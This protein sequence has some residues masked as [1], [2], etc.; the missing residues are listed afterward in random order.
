MA[1]GNEYGLAPEQ[2]QYRAIEKKHGFLKVRRNV[3]IEVDPDDP[4]KPSEETS[5]A[6]SR[7]AA[8]TESREEPKL[9]KEEKEDEVD[10]RKGG[11]SDDETGEAED[12][13]EAEDEAEDKAEAED[14][15]EDER[16][17]EPGDE[18][19]KPPEPP[20]LEFADEED[21]RAYRAVMRGE[22]LPPLRSR[23]RGEGEGK[24]KGKGKKKAGPKKDRQREERRDD[25]RSR[26][27]ERKS[28]GGGGR[29][30]RK[31]TG[32][33]PEPS[34]KPRREGRKRA[35]TET[36]SISR[37]EPK[38]IEPIE[39]R[40]KKAR[41][42]KA[43]AALEASEWLLDLVDLDVDCE[44]YEG[45]ERFEVEF[46]GRDRKFLVADSGKVL[47]GL[48]H[49][50]PRVMRG[51]CGEGYPIRT[52]SENFQVMREERLKDEALETAARVRREGEPAVLDAM[53]PADRRIVHI[54]LTDDP[55]VTTRSLGDGYFKRVKILPK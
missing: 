10:D 31:E 50:I 33:R 25:R 19:E 7:A 28:G 9:S 44:V 4:R 40:L 41:G 14:E 54:T 32:G 23:K 45:E 35:E 27:G 48:E 46:R 20:D 16:E 43:K 5:K 51:I 11:L 39:K 30:D 15:P 42:E 24:G 13:G 34:R 18:E 52:D 1:A 22:A 29:K 8:A 36:R 47:T 12:S 55:E 6:P 2:V 38:D 49:L 37:R 3:V 53:D 26:A 17:A 21:E